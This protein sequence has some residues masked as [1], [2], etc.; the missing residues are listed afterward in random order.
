[1]FYRFSSE[2]KNAIEASWAS[3][4]KPSRESSVVEPSRVER[5]DEREEGTRRR[6]MRSSSPVGEDHCPSSKVAS[7]AV[8]RD[9]SSAVGTSRVAEVR[10]NS[11][12]HVPGHV[13]GKERVLSQGEKT[14]S[15]SRPRRPGRVSLSSSSK[16]STKTRGRVSPSSSSKSSTK[17]V[18]TKSES[19]SHGTGGVKAGG[20]A[21][22]V[23]VGAGVCA[24]CG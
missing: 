17:R 3:S 22:G 1:M 23:P 18:S 6:A 11:T 24:G 13:P 7:S 2:L 12:D 4:A 19:S 9:L 5:G 10:R 14:R 21:A 8:P 15:P 16:S 20:A